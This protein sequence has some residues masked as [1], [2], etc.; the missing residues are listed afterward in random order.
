MNIVL[1]GA[2]NVATQLGLALKYY[3]NIL[4]VFS[5]QLTNASSLAKKLDSLATDNIQDIYPDADLYIISVQDDAIESI[6]NRL[7]TSNGIVVHTAG[8][9]TIEILNSFKNYGVFYPFQTFSKHRKISFSTIPILIE[10]NSERTT[11]QLLK[12]ASTLSRNTY[13]VS[14][15]QRLMIHVAAVFACN[16]TNYFY[17]IAKTISD[18]A[19][20]P[21]N[22]LQPLIKETAAKAFTTSPENAQTG[23]ASR[24]DKQTMQKHIEMLNQSTFE[25][26][27]LA[28][29]YEDISERIIAAI[30]N[31]DV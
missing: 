13:Q 2:G 31:T 6:V 8:S 27:N 1:I 16:F 19:E 23:P 17:H 11:T 14:T 5:R 4:Q 25:K 21:F 3:H 7:P 18:K 15:E 30:P 26:N 28:I 29:L 24:K 12:L 20:L 22:I 10:G 9:V